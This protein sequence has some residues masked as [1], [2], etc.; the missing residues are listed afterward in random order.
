MKNILRVYSGLHF[1]K[2]WN[3]FNSRMGNHFSAAITYFSF[4]SIIPILMIA[5]AAAGFMLSSKPQ[6]VRE[7][8]DTIVLSVKAPSLVS[9][10]ENIVNTAV[11]QR[12]TVGVIGLLLACYSG[13]GWMGIVKDAIS[14]QFSKKC[15]FPKNSGN[16]VVLYFTNFISF[17]SLLV[18]VALS[19]YVTSFL[20]GCRNSFIDS[21]NPGLKESIQ[22]VLFFITMILAM[23]PDYLI[24]FCMFW[25]LPPKSSN[26][27]TLL[28]GALLATLGLQ[29]IKTAMVYILPS[30]AKSPSGAMFGSVVG[31]LAFF[32]IFARLLLYCSA[33]IATAKENNP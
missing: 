18:V 24:F 17:L 8:V 26:F 2:A 1:V 11:S 13:L 19:V 32:N 28:R 22:P 6:L 5:F 21:L 10:L 7:F 3:R 23:V 15:E 20:I 33:W 12:T 14:A 25:I 9:I 30:L 27:K 29:V 31:L 4:L 16:I